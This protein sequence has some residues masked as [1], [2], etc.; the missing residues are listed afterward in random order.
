MEDKIVAVGGAGIIAL[1]IIGY[2]FYKRKR[3]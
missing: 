3:K 1:G 2:I